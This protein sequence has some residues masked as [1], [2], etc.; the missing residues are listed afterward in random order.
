M[1][2][3]TFQLARSFSDSTYP[4]TD[5]DKL[6]KSFTMDSE[7]INELEKENDLLTKKAQKRLTRKNRVTNGPKGFISKVFR[8]H[9]KRKLGKIKVLLNSLFPKLT[10]SEN[11]ASKWLREVSDKKEIVWQNGNIMLHDMESQIDVY[12]THLDFVDDVINDIKQLDYDVFKEIND[13]KAAFAF[14]QEI[15][16]K[17]SKPTS[18]N[19]KT[20]LV[21]LDSNSTKSSCPQETVH[22]HSESSS[23]VS[24]TVRTFCQDTEIS[25]PKV[26]TT[27]VSNTNSNIG[28]TEAIC[29]IPATWQGLKA[30]KPTHY[31]KSV[32]TKSLGNTATEA[33][34]DYS[35]TD[36]M[37]T[38]SATESCSSS[39]SS[40]SSNSN[41]AVINNGS[42]G[43][44]AIAF[45]NPCTAACVWDGA[46]YKRRSL[47][48]MSVS[49]ATLQPQ[50]NTSSPSHKGSS[51]NTK[52]NTKSGNNSSNL[53]TRLFNSKSNSP[54][55][56]HHRSNS[57]SNTNSEITSNG[58]LGLNLTLA[59][60]SVSTD[61]SPVIPVPVS[62]S[63]LSFLS[64]SSS[65]NQQHRS[66][67]HESDSEDND[68]RYSNT[69]THK[70]P[71]NPTS[72][73]TNTRNSN[74]GNASNGGKP[75]SLST[76]HS[77]CIAT[78]HDN[79]SNTIANNMEKIR[80]YSSASSSASSEES[81][82][83]SSSE[84]HPPSNT[85]TN[86]QPTTPTSSKHKKTAPTESKSLTVLALLKQIDCKDYSS[87]Q[88]LVDEDQVEM[89]RRIEK[90]LLV[91]ESLKSILMTMELTREKEM[92]T[93]RGVK[94]LK[95]DLKE[96]I[97]L[98]DAQIDQKRPVA[99][100]IAPQLDLPSFLLQTNSVSTAANTSISDQPLEDN[101]SVAL[102]VD[103]Q[104]T[105]FSYDNHSNGS[106]SGS[107]VTSS[108]TIQKLPPSFSSNLKSGYDDSSNSSSSNSTP[109]SVDK[110]GFPPDLLHYC[111]S[112]ASE[113]VEN[114]SKLVTEENEARDAVAKLTSLINNVQ[115]ISKELAEEMELVNEDLEPLKLSVTPSGGLTASSDIN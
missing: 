79:I 26:P 85:T 89:L 16:E 46:D 59:K 43:S 49:L 24:G 70:T 66:C 62:P 56:R 19:S 110:R 74:T 87:D 71:A 77:T 10:E 51:N 64:R 55:N 114:L 98:H 21:S 104:T 8:W 18:S 50:C 5:E 68:H 93:L 20:N 39:D 88:Q 7:K 90:C 57:T 17:Q 34:K 61:S 106:S 25:K 52:N 35:S 29:H 100:S 78:T 102:F 99:Q 94:R 91:K 113:C 105:A 45:L 76:P 69:T 111:W 58:L 13:I 47:Q 27:A 30:N 103:N 4:M 112:E 48:N 63:K 2:M 53:I 108:A 84:T 82:S 95:N 107:S 86:N 40:S 23:T 75:R 32:F 33:T 38:D 41:T 97:A 22:S 73:R 101:N 72:S 92:T 14:N 96:V 1:S 60:R 12:Q 31:A 109:Y 54:T 37:C 83:S 28:S 15:V 6:D 3:S 67:L 11:V 115:I 9:R 36:D 44:S 80:S 65:R 81:N 42:C